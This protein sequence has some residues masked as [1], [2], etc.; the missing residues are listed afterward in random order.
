MSGPLSGAVPSMTCSP[1]MT[2]RMPRSRSCDLQVAQPLIHLLGREARHAAQ[3][4]AG[5]GP[6][7]DEEQRL[8]VRDA[9]S[10]ALVVGV[11]GRLVACRVARLV[12]RRVA[13][14]VVLVRVCLAT[15]AHGHQAWLVHAALRERQT[16]GPKGFV[17]GDVELAALHQLEHGQ[18]RH[19]HDDAIAEVLEQILEHHHGRLAEGRPDDRRALLEGDQPRHD[20]RRW[21]GHG[22]QPQGHLQRVGEQPRVEGWTLVRAGAGPGRRQRGS[23]FPPEDLPAALETAPQG[24]AGVAEEPVE[25]ESLAQRLLGVRSVLDGDGHHRRARQDGPALDEDELA[26][27]AHE[28]ADVRHLLLVQSSQGLQVGPRQLPEGHLEDVQLALLDEPQQQRQGAVVALQPDVRRAVGV[29]GRA[30][31][32]RPS[33]PG[34]VSAAAAAPR[35]RSPGPERAAAA[36][37]PRSAAAWSSSAGLVGEV[38]GHAGVGVQRRG[39]VADELGGPLAAAGL[40]RQARRILGVVAESREGRPEAGQMAPRGRARRSP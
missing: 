11:F 5:Q 17:L 18:E 4:R 29:G 30:R 2:S 19:G 26:G 34:W 36:R 32:A 6:L 21:R 16:M 27:H 8:D 14:L 23:G 38:Q 24:A 28:G 22:S 3:L 13:S 40:P 39:L 31:C 1:E 12:A 10:A 33:R 9:G 7:G 37:R 25:D 20:L 35:R 15:R